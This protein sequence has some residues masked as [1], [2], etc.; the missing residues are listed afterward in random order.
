MEISETNAGSDSEYESVE[1]RPVLKQ[2]A[3]VV[4]GQGGIG[5]CAFITGTLTARLLGPVARGELAA[6]QICASLLATFATLGLS[7]ATTLYCARDPRN[8]R[9][10]VS[11]AILLSVIVGAPIF[12]LGYLAV[13]YMLSAQTRE[14]VHAARYYLLIVLFYI[15]FEFPHG[16]MRGLA[17]FAFWSAFRYIAPAASLIALTVAWLTGRI[18]PEF[19]AIFGLAMLG[20]LSL[21]SVLFMM[22]KRLS[23]PTRPD[24]NS[25]LPMLRFSVPLV[26]S[27]LPRQLNLRLDQ[28]VMAALLPP[29]LLGLYVV[30]TAWSTMT[31][32]MLEGVGAFL[33]PH[34]ASYDSADGRA[35]A[36]VQITKLATPIAVIE[37]LVLCTITPWG[38]IVVFG[39]PYRESI[40]AALILVVAGATLYLGQLLEEGLR[41]LGK[42]IPILRAE[43]GGLIVTAVS[44][45]VLLRPLAITGAAISS[46]L[47]YT[48]VWIILVAQI[49]VITGFTV[50]EILLPT[51]SELRSGW[52]MLREYTRRRRCVSLT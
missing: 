32:P 30:A 22:M 52:T 40:L 9:S 8:A 28:I 21:P 6:I 12:L 26:G 51:T 13:P 1:L 50:A 24:P 38:L 35:R 39:R 27:V 7:E 47:G 23:G 4:G 29:R 42:S 37:V 3:I 25:W 45:A 17:D 2:V 44:L 48:V 41:G 20:L 16:A 34:V 5:L 14:V 15:F 36:L 31:G 33:F 19:I 18:T 10:H 43:F 11:S 46:L 49:R